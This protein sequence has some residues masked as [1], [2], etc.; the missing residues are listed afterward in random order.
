MLR[1]ATYPLMADCRST[2]QA[3]AQRFAAIFALLDTVGP[4]HTTARHVTQE[5]STTLADFERI[6]IPKSLFL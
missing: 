5:P 4:L 6:G 2:P 1:S 3:V